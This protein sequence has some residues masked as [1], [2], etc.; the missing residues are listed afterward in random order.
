MKKNSL[1]LLLTAIIYGSAGYAQKPAEKFKSITETLRFY[2]IDDEK[3]LSNNTVN[4]IAQDSLGFIWI[5]TTDGLN[6]YDGNTFAKY[7]SSSGAPSLL[8]NYVQHIMV[9]KQ[10]KL[11]ISSNGGLNLF[12]VEKETFHSFT[13][14]NG[15]L[16]NN[17]NK[18][19]PGPSGSMIVG[20]YRGGIQ[21]LNPDGSLKN[22]ADYIDAPHSLSSNEISS[23]AMQGDSVLWAGT[24]NGGLNKIHL[25][26][27]KIN[28]ITFRPKEQSPT[29]NHI[30]TDKTGNVWIGSLKGLH[31]ITSTSDTIFVTAAPTASKGLSDAD[32]LSMQ[33]DDMGRMWI[34]TRNG[35]L[36]IVNTSEFLNKKG[37]LPFDWFLPREDGESVFN[38]TVSAIMK[39]REGNMWLGTSTGINYVNPHGEDLILLK[40]KPMSQETL[41]HSRVSSLEK[42]ESGNIWIGTDG[43]GLNLFNPAS[44]K[45]QLFQHNPDNNFSLSNDYILSLKKDSRGWLWVGTYRGGIN[46]MDPATGKC[47]RYLQG[48]VSKGSDVRC[49]LED[50][51]N[52]IWV[53]TNQGG[54][55]RYEEHSDTFTYIEKSGSL[56]I[57]DILQDRDGTFWLAT[58]GNGICHY[59]PEKDSIR[60]YNV[61][62]TPALPGNTIFSLSQTDENEIW[63]GVRYNG[64]VRFN[65]KTGKVK[66]FSEKEGLLNNTV[67]SLIREDNQNLWIGSLNGISHFHIPTGKITNL[68]FPEGNSLGELNINSVTKA[69]D[70]YL[71]FGGN[72]GVAIFHPEKIKKEKLSPPVVLTGLKL[73]NKK[74]PVLTN[75]QQAILN[76]APSHQKEIVLAYDQ[77]LF[78]I[79]FAALTYP[80]SKKVFYSYILEGYNDHWIESGNVGTA[81]F[82][83]LPAGRYNF[84][85]RA[86]LNP[87]SGNE[88]FTNLAIIIT[89]PFWKTIPAYILYGVILALLIYVALKYYTERVKLQNSLVF[90]K[91]QRQLE[92]DIN[93]ERLMFFTSFSHEL[94]T[95]LTLI[96]GPVED[97]ILKESKHK[98]T[99]G[100]VQKNARYLLQI[101]NKLLEF[102]KTEVGLNELKIAEYPLNSILKNW[103]KNYQHLAAKRKVTLTYNPPNQDIMVWVDLEK[104]QIMVYNLLSNAFK[105]TPLNGTIEVNLVEGENHVLIQVKDSGTGI[106]PDVLPRIFNWYY[107]SGDSKVKGTGIGLALTKRLTELHQGNLSVESKVNEGSVFTISLPL[108]QELSHNLQQPTSSGFS[109]PAYEHEVPNLPDFEFFNDTDECEEKVI[110]TNSEESREVLL[111]ID[112]NPGIIQYLTGLFKDDYHIINAHDGQQGLE[113]A[114]KYVPDLIISDVSMPEKNGLE[115]C[116]SL[117]QNAATTHI[118]VILLTVNDT[119]ESV[120][121]GFEEG[122]DLYLT[123]PFN[124][125]LLLT[126]V[127]SLLD[128]RKQLRTYFNTHHEEPLAIEEEGN[129]PLFLREKSFLEELEKTILSQIDSEETNVEAVAH[130]IG[131]SRKSLYRKIKAITG[132]NINEYIRSVKIKRAAK[133]ISEDGYNISQAAYAVGFSSVKYFRKHFKDQFGM[134]PSELSKEKEEE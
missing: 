101:I 100:L 127:K 2:L 75:D 122:A 91:K 74:V 51:Q 123:K 43:G 15:L 30:Y 83:N 34:G 69:P 37:N 96:L 60:F 40:R 113:K 11:W 55:Y 59:N 82:S 64:L 58:F 97:L 117:K 54:L 41:A 105:F 124:G 45:L 50:S 38:R 104:L 14:D 73:F 115:L 132:Q 4:S 95:P 126:Q 8:N 53:G 26:D 81:N 35:G 92:H 103:V 46:R 90:E 108:D 129:S 128:K 125:Q 67:N 57:R 3:G 42:E 118:P 70:G 114:S 80:S 88:S 116:R 87:G 99:L 65:A 89:P 98:K 94:K 131:M 48:S 5:G 76:K 9:D 121:E 21:F 62:N 52:R 66:V 85:V 39:D 86:T 109:E 19:I 10:G 36:N 84:K 56:D 112:D 23:L 32:V 61:E 133:L 7:K 31:V 134:L 63:A 111:L 47:K 33:E 120:K 20:I 71:Y 102:R 25:K 18:A 130:S 6:R 119:L 28:S 17:V 24:F 72:K 22:L 16:L 79:D 44:G 110:H 78:S 107:K 27:R 29:V 106:S 49:I 12:D 13:T 93:E 77:S 68:A 1:I